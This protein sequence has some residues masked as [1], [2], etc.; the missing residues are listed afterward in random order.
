MAIRWTPTVYQ[1][2]K[3]SVLL[4]PPVEYRAVAAGPQAGTVT[5]GWRLCCAPM[6]SELAQSLAIATHVT[7]CLADSRD[8][9]T[10]PADQPSFPEFADLVAFDSVVGAEAW[11]QRL[12]GD[13]VDRLWLAVSRPAEFITP[14]G[15]A[16]LGGL[17]VG[18]LSTGTAGSHLW[19]PQWSTATR[20]ADGADI[21]VV[22]YLSEP[23]PVEPSRIGIEAATRELDAVLRR[24]TDFADRE[25]L[26]N[27]AQVF[28]RARQ[29]PAPDGG[30]R[31]T[32][33]RDLFPASW[34]DADGPR[35]AGTALAAWVF[36]GMGSW[37][38]LGFQDDGVQREYE[39]I[40][41]DL[42]DAVLRAGI[43][44]VNIDL[45]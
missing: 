23:A 35:L 19:Q 29:Q 6:N 27:W 3:T 10:P 15:A 25:D 41:R 21:L 17:P 26:P 37:N 12:A 34:P 22:N 9:H 36:G 31:G 16:F 44:A 30:P 39:Q 18:L 38:D 40:S 28:T 14:V 20:A 32:D 24:A 42:L 2:S 11:A 8:G 4:M 7:M 45:S 1:V 13:G 33:H 5:A 43:A